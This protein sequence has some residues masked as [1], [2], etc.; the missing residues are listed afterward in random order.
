MGTKA[1][2]CLAAR[3]RKILSKALNVIGTVVGRQRDAGEQDLDVSGVERGEDGIEIAARLIGRKT[4]QAVV[5]AEFHD[6]D[7][8]MRPC[9][10]ARMLAT[11]SF[12]GG[13]AG[14][15][16]FDLVVVAA[17]VEVALQCVGI[18]LAG[19]QSVPGRDAVAKAD[20]DGPAGGEQRESRQNQQQNETSSLRQTST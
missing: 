12:G 2:W 14:A 15:L 3:S 6:D 16:I 11:A 20:E 5:A 1:A 9:T 19:L 4:A 10:I 8:G 18:G 13:A 7:C 17:L